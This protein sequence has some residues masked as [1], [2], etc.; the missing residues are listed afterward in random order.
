MAIKKDAFE[1]RL[2]VGDEQ[3]AESNDVTLW[4]AVFSAINQGEEGGDATR[5][6]SDFLRNSQIGDVA[7]GFA[8]TSLTKFAEMIGTTE[9][10]LQG[11][12]DPQKEEPYLHL[13]ERCW[14]EWT[15]NMPPRG[16]KAVSAASLAAT[17]LCLWFR[18][19]GIEN[20][21]LRQ[22][23]N[24]LSIIGAEGKNPARSIKNCSWLQLRGGQVLRL[25]PAAIEQAIEVVKAF[26]EKRTPQ[27]TSK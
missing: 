14:A 10:I 7:P 21:T 27:L 16:R 26:C 5:D 1:V 9:A 18:S 19:A 22:S 3:V 4:Q 13:N 8:D 20:P 11:A 15:K 24:I 17:L 2:F 12:C 6:S 25:N 23:Q